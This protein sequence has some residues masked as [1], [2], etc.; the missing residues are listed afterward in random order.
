MLW[1]LAGPNFHQEGLLLWVTTRAM[2]DYP[3][4]RPAKAHSEE[5]RTKDSER[6]DLTQLLTKDDVRSFLFG[7]ESQIVLTPSERLSRSRGTMILLR[8]TDFSLDACE[9]ISTQFLK[10]KLLHSRPRWV[11]S[12]FLAE[13]LYTGNHPLRRSLVLVLINA[14]G[15]RPVCAHT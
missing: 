4:H 8:D 15:V 7:V 12:L 2:M 3:Q 10:N 14:K 1:N 13:L 9:M 6:L 11:C 5:L